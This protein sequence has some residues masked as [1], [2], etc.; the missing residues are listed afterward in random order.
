V[1]H[2]TYPVHSYFAALTSNLRTVHL[3]TVHRSELL[4]HLTVAPLAHRTCL[5]HTEQS[6]NYSGASL[7]NP[8]REMGL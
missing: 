6:V 8:E 4:A 1:A 2:R 5:V 7:E 3:F